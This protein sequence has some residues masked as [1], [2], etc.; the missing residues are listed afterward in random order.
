MKIRWINKTNISQFVE[1]K[2]IYIYG[3][4]SLG[5]VTA[6]WLERNGYNRYRFCVDREY[7]GEGLC[8]ID[9]CLE[10]VKLGKAIC[11]FAIGEADRYEA[12]R[13]A[14]DDVEIHAVFDPFE[15]WEYD[16]VDYK[17]HEKELEEAR[18]VLADEKSKRTFDS[19]IMAKKTGNGAQCLEDATISGKYFNELT[20]NI[21][22]GAYVDCGAY[23]GDTIE[24]FKSYYRSFNGKIYAFEP[25]KNNY[26]ALVKKMGDATD[27]YLF[28]KGVWDSETT[29]V[30][31]E[32]EGQRSEVSYDGNIKID[33]ISLDEAIGENEKIA[34]VKIGMGNAERVL[35]GMERMI[36]QNMPIISMLSLYSL[37]DLYSLP[38]ILN[39]FSKE[40]KKYK[41][42]L[43]H[44]SKTSSGLL[45]YY[46]IPEKNE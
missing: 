36:Q 9:E 45:F 41:V 46:A 16:E 29:L 4:G 3:Y 8:L 28:N 17:D 34:Y 24:L 32:G 5:R 30:F 6:K 39:K 18:T 35:S 13:K 27:T 26:E 7:L 42:Y 1:N 15:F 20:E 31:H 23:N 25:D 38:L 21:G 33:V 14:C 10:K 43:R 12:F 22:E 44:H 19:Y 37:Q 40:G 2:E 11:I